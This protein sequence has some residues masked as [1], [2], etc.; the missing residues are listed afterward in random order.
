MRVRWK[1]YHVLA[2]ERRVGQSRMLAW[3]VSRFHWSAKSIRLTPDR[4]FEDLGHRRG[5]GVVRR[6]AFLD[7]MRSPSAVLPYG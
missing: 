4:D 2:N 1:V 7:L 6:T 3:K 5:L